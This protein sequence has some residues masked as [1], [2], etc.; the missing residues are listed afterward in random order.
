MP[1]AQSS[2]PAATSAP[3]APAA[4]GEYKIVNWSQ[5]GTAPGAEFNVQRDGNSG[6]SFELN[7]PVPTAEITGTF[8]GKPLTGIATN[9]VIV[10]A[11]IPG[12]YL[13]E[14]GTYPVELQIPDLGKKIPAGNFEVK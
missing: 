1:P 14:A 8:D 2:S 6:I 3:A 9:G 5:K 7:Q 13:A 11:T 4:A 12:E 10:T